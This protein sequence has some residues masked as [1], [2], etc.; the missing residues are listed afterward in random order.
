MELGDHTKNII[1]NIF[2]ISFKPS[3]LKIIINKFQ[4]N[5]KSILGVIM[6]LGDHTKNIIFNIFILLIKI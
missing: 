6:E 1:F 3:G 5:T 2:I 4:K